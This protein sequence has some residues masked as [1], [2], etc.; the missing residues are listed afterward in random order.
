MDNIAEKLQ[1]IQDGI[2]T[3]GDL[4]SQ[5]A[6]ALE[7][8]SGN[9][10]NGQENLETCTVTLGGSY[11]NTLIYTT[12]KDNKAVCYS[13]YL[14]FAINTMLPT[15]TVLKNSFIVYG[16]PALTAPGNTITTSGEC[17]IVTE[18]R[19]NSCGATFKI[20]GDCSITID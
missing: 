10:E 16:A 20:N 17:E 15:V 11:P 5:I 7:G 3:E 6:I 13:V 9:V 8:K 19:T 14:P 4:I 1:I 18:L 12:V 2:N